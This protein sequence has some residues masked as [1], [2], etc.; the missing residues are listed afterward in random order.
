M[1]KIKKYIAFSLI[2]CLGTLMLFQGNANSEEVNIVGSTSIQ[3]VCE[4]LVEEYR[5]NRS[6]SEITVQGGGSNMAIKCINA[7]VADIGMCSKQLNKDYDFTEYEL[8]REGIVVAVHPSNNVSDLTINE[9]KGIFDGSI[10]N[11][12]QLGGENKSINVFVREEGSGTLDAF[13]STIMNQTPI[14]NEAIVL[15]SQ[16]SIKQSVEQDTSSIGIVSFSYL[17]E[18]IKALHVDGIYPS[19]KS[20]ADESY[21]LQRPFLL[22]INDNSTNE[23]QNFINWL[24]STEANKILDENRI[25]RGV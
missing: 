8:G 25:I 9:I 13:K 11:W 24:N 2:I 1:K 5:K 12:N 4:D 23:T 21:I 17:D 15:N 10:T 20:I 6:K 22:L 7:D 3:P 18:N 19:E 14:L 16:G